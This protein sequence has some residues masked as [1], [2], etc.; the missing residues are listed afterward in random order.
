MHHSY[1]LFLF[2]FIVYVP[3][4]LQCPLSGSNSTTLCCLW[5]ASGP[6]TLTATAEKKAFAPGIPSIYP[7]KVH[8]I[9]KKINKSPSVPPVGET[10]KIICEMSNASSRIVTPKVKLLQKQNFYTH[11]K[12]SK[13]FLS[14]T[15]AS[16][17][18]HPISPHSSEVHA[19]L[20]L[21]IPSSVPYSISNCSILEVQYIIEVG[22]TDRWC[23][24]ELEN[25]LCN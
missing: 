18:G 20:L 6:I 4:C 23:Y 13:R 10:V 14:Q 8:F 9:I 1:I 7:S 22:E 25:V 12:V 16:M 2:Y 11:N 15:M 5:C 17:N 3:F 19:E 21:T 24:I